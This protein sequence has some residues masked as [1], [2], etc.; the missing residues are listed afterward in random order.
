[1]IVWTK[2]ML[3]L[4]LKYP[5]EVSTRAQTIGFVNSFDYGLRGPNTNTKA[6]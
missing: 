3:S 1:M 2:F 4:Q 5:F 6:I